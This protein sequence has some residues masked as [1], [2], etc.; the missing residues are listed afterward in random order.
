MCSISGSYSNVVNVLFGTKFVEQCL[1]ASEN[2]VYI[3]REAKSCLVEADWNQTISMASLHLSLTHISSST[4]VDD[5]PLL[6]DQAL[7]YGS[8]LGLESS[9][10][11]SRYILRKPMF[12]NNICCY[13]SKNI[14]KLSF[15]DHLASSKCI[16]TVYLST[17]ISFSVSHI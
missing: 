6:W 10:P 8:I 13:C 1:A 2:A 3:V 14:S 5:W 17:R 7:D 16:L 12:G 15:I 11:Y 9:K 4:L